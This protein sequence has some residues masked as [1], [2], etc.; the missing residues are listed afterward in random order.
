MFILLEHGLSFFIIFSLGNCQPGTFINETTD[1]CQVCPIGQYQDEP[2]K[3]SCKECGENLS[4]EKEGSSSSDAC[5]GT[6][7]SSI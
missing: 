7:F 4:T 3:T 2:R 6:V 5:Q 1:D